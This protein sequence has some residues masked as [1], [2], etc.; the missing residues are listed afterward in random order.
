MGE[1]CLEPWLSD[2]TVIDIETTGL[3]VEHD[4][5]IELS[6]IKIRDSNEH[7]SFS[8]L[9]KPS[10]EI[11][12][13]IESLTGITNEML[14]CEKPIDRVINEYREFIGDDVIV[15][16]N[17]GFDLR[18]INNN[19]VKNGMMKI[20]NEYVDTLSLSRKVIKDIVNHKL[21]SLSCYFKIIEPRHRGIADCYSTNALYKK[22]KIKCD[23]DGIDLE[24][25]KISHKA[26]L[27]CI[28][29]SI[30]IVDHTTFNGNYFYGRNVVVTGKLDSMSKQD[31]GQMVVNVGG[32][33]SDSVS[34]DTDVLVLGDS[35]YQNAH[36]LGKSNKHKKAE[37]LILKGFEIDII[38]E[39]TFFQY[40]AL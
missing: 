2:Y 9:V 33:F 29:P 19:L 18:F 13:F 31:L 36:F 38:D 15:G 12:E 28:V 40:I 37:D 6:A 1:K 25:R 11:D 5:I 24:A 27:N 35:D 22:L 39:A 7:S 32:R 14:M 21:K 17:I 34:K 3:V 8:V 30:D 10:R 4:E 20:E 26:Q 23:E 16:H